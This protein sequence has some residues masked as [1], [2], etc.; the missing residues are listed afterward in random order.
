MFNYIKS[1]INNYRN[2]IKYEKE[3]YTKI[4]ETIEYWN[5]VKIIE[6]INMG[7]KEL[8]ILKKYNYYFKTFS[9]N[10]VKI[11]TKEG[12]IANTYIYK[13]ILINKNFYWYNFNFIDNYVI[14]IY[15][16]DGSWLYQSE[17]LY[18]NEWIIKEIIE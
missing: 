1:K 8:Y 9:M 3:I 12:S 16:D 11:L 18:K 5:E 2:K 10:N 15:F 13:N 7:E 14:D 6:R 17:V 4:I